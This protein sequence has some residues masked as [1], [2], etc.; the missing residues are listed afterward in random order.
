MYMHAHR[1]TL[2]HWPTQP[3]TNLTQSHNIAA[4][5]RSPEQ[6]VGHNQPISPRIVAKTCHPV[7]M[8]DQLLG[9][10]ELFKRCH[11][12]HSCGT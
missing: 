6:M 2:T 1:H 3:D 4:T 12:P 11:L 8:L 9:Y 5:Q 7:S 10:E